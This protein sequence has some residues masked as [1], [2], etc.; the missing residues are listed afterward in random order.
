M[1]NTTRRLVLV[2]RRKAGETATT[3][4]TASGATVWIPDAAA[5]S[6]TPSPSPSPDLWANDPDRTTRREAFPG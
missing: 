5:E 3:I 6:V 4:T 1:T 2:G